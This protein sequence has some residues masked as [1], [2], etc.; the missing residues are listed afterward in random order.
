MILKRNIKFLN[1]KE[2]LF[3]FILLTPIFLIL[4]VP[5]VLVFAFREV[6]RVITPVKKNEQTNRREPYF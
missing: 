5:A 3:L 6:F 4:A 2:S 1:R